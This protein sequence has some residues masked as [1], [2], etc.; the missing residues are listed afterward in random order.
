MA[1]GRGDVKTKRRGVVVALPL[2]SLRALVG[3]LRVT[4]GRSSRQSR[5]I[6][7]DLG[8]FAAWL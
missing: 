4:C 7:P 2:G 3:Y 6:R 1:C 5:M 8:S